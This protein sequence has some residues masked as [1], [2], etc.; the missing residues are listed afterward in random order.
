MSA[1][2]SGQQ[3]LLPLWEA[4]NIAF[5][6]PDSRVLMY[7]EEPEAHLFPH[8]QSNLMKYLCSFVAGRKH[9]RRLFI[10]TH[11]PYVLTSINN[12]MKA[13]SIA[14]GSS[15]DRQSKISAIIPK[16]SWISRNQVS[17]YAIVDHKL[18]NIIGEDNLID[19][20]YLDRVSVQLN[21]EFDDLLEIE[22][23]TNKRGGARH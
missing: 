16:A 21:K 2:S 18:V 12:M 10:T 22:I 15:K 8:A 17:A 6:N 9:K 14:R 13:A 19:A 20:E 11:S 5:L 3:E 4:L 23:T 1:L 7:I